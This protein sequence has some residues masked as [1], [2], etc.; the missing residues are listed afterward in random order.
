MKRTAQRTPGGVALLLAIFLVGLAGC[1]ASGEP[2]ARRNP[3][4]LTADEMA[5]SSAANLYEVV[6]QLRPRWFQV[7][8]VTSLQ[9]QNQQVGV[10]VNRVYQGG[11]ETLRGMPKSGV[12]QLRYLDGPTASAQLR[13]PG[14]T[15]LAG[16]IVVETSATP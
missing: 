2:G 14:A 8:S 11:T 6:E 3:N 9:G 4:L 5:E 10:F 15:A 7:R 1:A 13:T 16:A 12:A